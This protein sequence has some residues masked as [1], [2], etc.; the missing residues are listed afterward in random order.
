MSKK[1]KHFAIGDVVNI[2]KNLPA[3]IVNVEHAQRTNRVIGYRYWC[4]WHAKGATPPYIR[5][6]HLRECNP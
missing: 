5:A 6:T 1:V 2:G 3:V 4:T